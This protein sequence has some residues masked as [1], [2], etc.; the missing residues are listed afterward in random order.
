MPERFSQE[1]FSIDTVDDSGGQFKATLLWDNIVSHLESMKCGRH[2]QALRTFNN[3][4]QGSAAVDSLLAH[5]SI[6]LSK[7]I[8]REQIQILCQK[9]L[10]TGVIE[11]VRNKEKD[12]FRESRLYRHTRNHFW[13]VSNINSSNQNPLEV[14][15]VSI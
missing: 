14:C 13:S 4:F 2:S 11:D 1:N 6:I 12:V 7:V 8:K 3:C 9:L 15:L 10:G 5:L